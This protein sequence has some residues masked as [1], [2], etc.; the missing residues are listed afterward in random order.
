MG[1]ADRGR[2]RRSGRGAGPR[3]C[4]RAAAPRRGAQPSGRRSL[5][6]RSSSRPPP[7][8]PAR[9]VEVAAGHPLAPLLRSA[10][11]RRPRRGRRP[12]RCRL[13]PPSR[14]SAAR[15]PAR[16]PFPRPASAPQSTARL[17]S[18]STMAK[19]EIETNRSRSEAFAQ[20]ACRRTRSRAPSRPI[21]T[22]SGTTRWAGI[23][24]AE[25]RA[26][27]RPASSAAPPTAQTGGQAPALGFSG[28]WLEPVAGAPDRD[29]PRW[30]RGIGLDLL[31]QSAHVHGYGRGV[32]V[33]G[34]V[35]ESV[36]QVDAAERDPG[37]LGKEVEQVE[38]LRRQRDAPSPIERRL[39][40]R[41]D[42]C[43]DRRSSDRQARLPAARPARLLR[44]RIALTRATISRGENGL[45]T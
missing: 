28:S 30:P 9:A 14:R 12:D 21:A 25:R 38:L 7:T 3:S 39:A 37:V 26:R 33:I 42:R 6:R 24:A 8:R 36:E 29:Q 35:P 34:D 20:P 41:P 15:P 45:A 17:T 4:A 44:R 27:R 43:S 1:F 13:R 40:R 23:A 16:R 18:P 19:A 32:A 31:A 5:A 10:R 22:A 2:P 11:S